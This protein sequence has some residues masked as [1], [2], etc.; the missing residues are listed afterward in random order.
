M[1]SKRAENMENPMKY[2]IHHIHIWSVVRIAFVFFLLL[3]L[4]FGVVYL[5]MMGMLANFMAFSGDTE[6]AGDFFRFSGLVGVMGIFILA[7][8]HSA[9]WSALIAV[10]LLVYNLLG[11]VRFEVDIERPLPEIGAAPRE[12][13]GEK[14]TSNN[15]GAGI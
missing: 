10:L 4:F 14:R 9:L 12:P 1:P 2:H 5:L 8:M 7:F 13:A 11:G 3:G 15:Q 6:M